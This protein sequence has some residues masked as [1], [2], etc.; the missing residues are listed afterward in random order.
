MTQPMT[1]KQIIHK[2]VALGETISNKFKSYCVINPESESDVVIGNCITSMNLG[3]KEE[4]KVKLIAK[5]LII[6]DLSKLIQILDGLS[7]EF[8]KRLD[9]DDKKLKSMEN[10]NFHLDKITTKERQYL[11]NMGKIEKLQLI[12]NILKIESVKQLELLSGMLK[13]D[14]PSGLT[15]LWWKEEDVKK[16]GKFN[17]RKF[18][19]MSKNISSIYMK[20]TRKHRKQRGGKWFWESSEQP[21]PEGETQA[22]TINP[23][24]NQEPSVVQTTKPVSNQGPPA[25]R[26]IF[27]YIFGTKKSNST[28]PPVTTDVQPT[29]VQVAPQVSLGGSR[30]RKLKRRKT[31]RR[32]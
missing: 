31:S 20:R 12:G 4:G 21:K 29:Q 19:R 1:D 28:A 6:D 11:E 22:Q 15:R 3:T 10:K 7:P 13:I 8:K 26:G 24:Q 9:I 25:K 18:R 23:L 5:L 16:G 17:D 27:N 14:F 32:R 2:K 30:K